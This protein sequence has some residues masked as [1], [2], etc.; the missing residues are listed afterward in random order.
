[1]DIGSR[2]GQLCS[3]L[4]NLDLEIKLRAER[5]TAILSELEV[6]QRLAVMIQAKGASHVPLGERPNEA[7]TTP[8]PAP[9]G[10]VHRAHQEGQEAG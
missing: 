10:R 8:A 6:L 4:G 3:E 1:M 2:Y 9:N 7:T 5:R